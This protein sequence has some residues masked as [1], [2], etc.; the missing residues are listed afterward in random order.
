MMYHAL[1]LPAAQI[2]TI[3]ANLNRDPKKQRKPYSVDDFTF[4]GETEEAKPEYRAAIAYMTL[5]ARNELP[6]WALFCHNDFKS[7]SGKTYPTDPAMRGEGFL[8]LAPTENENKIKG[9]MVA[10]QRVSGK[11]IAVT[12]E[13]HK[14][15]ISV[16][17]FDGY[18]CAKADTEV[19]V[20]RQL[21]E[22]MI[23]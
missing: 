6:G 1:E 8:L 7:G 17:K 9:L 2:C 21:A 11:Q 3:T 18:V 12:W 5:L 16:P 19:T 13:S 22:G 10:E 15:M 14:M 20:L 23:P 4:F